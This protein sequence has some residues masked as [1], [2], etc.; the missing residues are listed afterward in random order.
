MDHPPAPRSF[1]RRYVWSYDHKVVGKQYLWTSLAFLVLGGTLA[2][3][4]RWQI[5]FPGRPVPGLGRWLAGRFFFG[6]EGAVTPDG[7]LQMA[8]THGLIMIFFVVIPLIV[9]GFGNFLIPLQIG[10]RDVAFP[11]LNALSYWLY[12]PSGL[13]MLASFFVP[14]GTAEAGWTNYP[15]LS[16]LGGAVPSDLGLTLVLTAVYF[17]GFSSIVG[18]LNFLATIVMMRAPGMT[19]G[20]LSLV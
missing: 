9:G 3:L 6:Q 12:L 5:G 15:P 10:A 18:G 4:L 17:V 1:F 19:W 13:C 11:W 14:H 7:Y 8:A 20:R 2:M 16:A